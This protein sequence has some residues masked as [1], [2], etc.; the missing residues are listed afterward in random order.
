MRA[1]RPLGD[2][3]VTPRSSGDA[4]ALEGRILVTGGSGFLGSCLVGRLVGE[5]HDVVCATRSTDREE[6]HP[7][8]TWETCD[9]SE[10]ADVDSLFALARPEIV[11]HLA[12]LASGIR[13]PSNV[14][15]TLAGNLT[16][17]VN[18]LMAALS[19]GTRRVVLT[20]SYEEPEIGTPPR[21]PYAASKAAATSYAR[22]FSLLY[23]LSTVVLRPAMVYGPGQRDATK[24]IP[25]V[26]RCFL[27]GEAPE[28]SSGRRPVDWVYVEDVADA[29]FAAAV[30]PGISGEV[31]DVGSGE[32]R[33][34]REIVDALA[35]KT[36]ASTPPRF[37]DLPD[38]PAE[39]AGAAD[40]TR[41]LALLGW[42]AQTS[43]DEGLSRTVDAFRSFIGA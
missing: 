43:L 8:A 19:S 2:L 14:E 17:S 29:F 7:G 34:I 21:S 11:F 31:I 5:G 25:Y 33:T 10:K 27:T 39:L 28:L 38:R 13:E 23:G 40:T 41:A 16:A 9:L 24:L 32:L 15:P 42:K 12:G 36:G 37:G 18:V 6:L 20:G 35:A 1:G 30:T 22:M 26:T 4:P 3:A